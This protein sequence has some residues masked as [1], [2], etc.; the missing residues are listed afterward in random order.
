MIH[1]PLAEV[2]L[3]MAQTLAR[4]VLIAAVMEP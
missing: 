3:K 1:L 4:A 2:A